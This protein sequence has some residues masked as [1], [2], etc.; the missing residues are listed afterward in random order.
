MIKVNLLTDRSLDKSSNKLVGKL[1]YNEILKIGGGKGPKKEE[2]P[3]LK[4]LILILPIA[5]LYGYEK[6]IHKRAKERVA[7]ITAELLSIETLRD[8]KRAQVAVIEKQKKELEVRQPIL[9]EL[10]KISQEK[11]QGVIVMDRL[12]DLIPYQVWLS[13]VTYNRFQ[14]DI[15]GFAVTDN[16]LTLFQ[17]NFE[18]SNF[19]TDILIY[20]SVESKTENANYVAFKMKANYLEKIGGKSGS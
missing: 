12:Q 9:K 8:E 4:L 16:D 18:D 1:T 20:N 5:L 3:A 14:L 11:I 15:S 7:F 2:G 10:K 6:Y 13:D 17:K 19:F